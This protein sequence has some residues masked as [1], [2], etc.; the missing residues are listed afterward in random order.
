MTN[1]I[2]LMYALTILLILLQ[3]VQR[4]YR[5]VN[6]HIKLS[7]LTGKMLYFNL[8]LAALMYLIVKYVD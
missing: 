5:V 3:S 2:S 1:I 8:K 4:Q 6:L 7:K